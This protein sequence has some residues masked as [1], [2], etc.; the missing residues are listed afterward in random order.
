MALYPDT[1]SFYRAIVVSG[2]VTLEKGKVGL[3]L[4]SFFLSDSVL[5][6]FAAVKKKETTLYNLM[7]EDDDEKIRPIPVELVVEIP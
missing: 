1:T 4:S 7:F 5:T 6:H 3:F 2:P